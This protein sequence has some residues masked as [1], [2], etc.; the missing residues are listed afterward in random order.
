MTEE[1]REEKFF[2][3]DGHNYTKDDLNTIIEDTLDIIKKY[4]KHFK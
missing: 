3:I 1:E 4:D 2:E